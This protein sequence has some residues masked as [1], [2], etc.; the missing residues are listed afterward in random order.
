MTGRIVVYLVGDRWINA[1]RFNGQYSYCSTRSRAEIFFNQADAQWVADQEIRILSELAES[2]GRKS[3][4]GKEFALAAESVKIITVE[5][6]YVIMRRSPG[7]AV[8]RWARQIGEKTGYLP[9]VKQAK[10]RFIEK[11]EQFTAERRRA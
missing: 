1:A 5:I 9:S 11:T 4:T 3:R 10:Q 8:C 2:H 7:V 6:P